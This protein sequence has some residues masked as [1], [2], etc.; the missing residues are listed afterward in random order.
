MELPD[1]DRPP[2][3]IWLDND[4][5]NDHFDSVRARYRSGSSDGMEP[6]EDMDLVSNEYTRDLRK[7][8]RG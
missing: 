2:E 7:S 4:A 1:E 3:Q 6:I 5:L 8:L